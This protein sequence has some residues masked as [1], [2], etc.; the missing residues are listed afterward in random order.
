ML[1]FR[2][3]GNDFFAVHEVVS[4]AKGYCLEGKGP[5]L[6]EAMTYRRGAHSTSDDPS[7]Y[8]SEEEV[9]KWEK[10]DPITRLGKY[11]RAKDLWNDSKEKD[12]IAK[13]SEE[14]TLAINNAKESPKPP[15][16]TLFE[17]V[18]FEMPQRLK[19]QYEE[20]KSFFSNE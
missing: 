14:I 13:T 16:K 4:K 10:K 15:L 11:L 3:D 12:L 18:Y 17:H 9:L 19:A 5:V 2:V 20:V 8:R 6:I 1:T 7:L